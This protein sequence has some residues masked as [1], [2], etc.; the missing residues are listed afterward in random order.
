M[1]ELFVAFKR[2]R[3]KKKRA[4]VSIW[5]YENSSLSNFPLFFFGF[6][7]YLLKDA[8][9]ELGGIAIDGVKSV[10]RKALNTVSNS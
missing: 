4:D 7:M 10:A 8:P 5:E 2:S 3:S 6:A 1:E 9:F